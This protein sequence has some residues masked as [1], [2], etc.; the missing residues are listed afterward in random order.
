MVLLKKEKEK[1]RK[2]KEEAGDYSLYGNST[3]LGYELWVNG[4]S[5]WANILG[6]IFLRIGGGSF[7]IVWAL[8]MNGQISKCCFATSPPIFAPIP[9]FLANQ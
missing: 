2:N 4:F 9:P 7:K 8:I 3:L 1:E 6:S 5:L